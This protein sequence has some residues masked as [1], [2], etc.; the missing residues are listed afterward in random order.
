MVVRSARVK[1][2]KPLRPAGKDDAAGQEGDDGSGDE[3]KQ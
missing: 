1:V 2:A 3:T